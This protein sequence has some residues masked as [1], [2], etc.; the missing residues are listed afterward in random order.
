[1]VNMQLLVGQTEWFG[2]IDEAAMISCAGTLGRAATIDTWE[3]S[4]L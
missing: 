3:L 4:I 1:M 2:L